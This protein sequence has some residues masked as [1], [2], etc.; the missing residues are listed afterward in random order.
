LNLRRRMAVS[1]GPVEA[2]FLVGVRYLRIDEDLT[3]HSE[4]NVP[5]P[6][7]AINDAV[8][9]TDNDMTGAQIGLQSQWMLCER[10]WI[11]VE[12]K[13]A[14]FSNSASLRT[15]YTNTDENGAVTQFV[16]SDQKTSTTYLLETSVLVN[17][18]FTPGLTFRVGYTALWMSGMALGSDNFSS[19]A[20]RLTLGPVLIN[21]RGRIAWHGPSIGLVG[22][23]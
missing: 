16:D 3:Y 19:N 5:L 20:D 13:G 10:S 18:Q 9:T 2:S 6:G 15:R 7:G 12:V 4:A 1:S 22:A 8:L 23:W 21:D 11:D 17:Y 14:I